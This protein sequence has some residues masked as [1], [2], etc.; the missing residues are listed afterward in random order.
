[1]VI[2]NLLKNGIENI[3]GTWNSIKPVWHIFI[4]S[5]EIDGVEETITKMKSYTDEE[6]KEEIIV[7]ANELSRT[8]NYIVSK[9]KVKLGNVL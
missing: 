2:L 6:D 9:Q 5:N 4:D 1:M 8:I 7:N 3:E